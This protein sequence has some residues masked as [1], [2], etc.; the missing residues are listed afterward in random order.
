MSWFMNNKY[1]E[2]KAYDLLGM[3]YYYEGNIKTS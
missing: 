2:L 1:Y 3:I